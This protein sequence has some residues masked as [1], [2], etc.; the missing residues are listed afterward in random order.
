LMASGKERFEHDLVVRELVRKLELMGARAEV[1]NQPS[2]RQLRHVL[3]LSTSITARL[4]GPPHVLTLMSRLHPTPAVGGVPEDT[5]REF[6]RQQENFERGW[7]A[8]PIGWFDGQGDGEFV[9]ALRSGLLTDNVLRL[10]A[11]AGIVRDSKPEK[12]LQEIELKLQS[13]LEA[14]G[15]NHGHLTSSGPI[16]NPHLNTP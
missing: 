6:M 2:I 14:I 9:V 1:P 11:G 7:Y 12:E 16:D 3:H 10:Y 15:A 5:A 13:L 8:A 4:F